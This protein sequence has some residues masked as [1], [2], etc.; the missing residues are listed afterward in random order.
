MAR[1]GGLYALNKARLALACKP[2]APRQLPA[3][4][5]ELDPER[6]QPP[7]YQQADLG[8]RQAVAEMEATR[9]AELAAADLR[10]PRRKVLQSLAAHWHGLIIFVDQPQIPMDNNGAERAARPA[11]V[12]RKNYYG[13]GSKWS[14]DLLAMLM[15]LLQT[16]RLHRIDPRA[17]LTAYLEACANHGSKAPADITPWLPWNFVPPAPA[18]ARDLPQGGQPRGP[19]P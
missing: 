5:V 17:Y 4:F 13:S 7:A 1:I 9:R 12:A 14:G 2:D 10:L 16:L 11:A 8:L 18:T 15:S 19:A 3:P 6:M